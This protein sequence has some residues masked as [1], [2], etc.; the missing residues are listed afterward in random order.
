V[1]FSERRK[2][3]REYYINGYLKSDAWSRKR[4]VVLKG[5][6]WTCVYCG[7]KATKVHHIKYAKKNIGKEPIELLVFLC[8]TCHENIHR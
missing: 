4:Y 1:L 5:D 8:K 6:N 3:R 2:R 7:N